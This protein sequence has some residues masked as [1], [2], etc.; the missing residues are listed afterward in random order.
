MWQ[1]SLITWQAAHREESI[2]RNQDFVQVDAERGNVYLR[3]SGSAVSSFCCTGVCFR[4][5]LTALL[6]QK[7]ASVR[8]A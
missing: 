4:A 3:K 5:R 8:N 7:K 2:L 6:A 1:S